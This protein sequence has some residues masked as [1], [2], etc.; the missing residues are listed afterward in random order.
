MP[1]CPVN[2]VSQARLNDSNAFYN[3][4][5][6]TLYLR[7]TRQPRQVLGYVPRINNSFIFET[8]PNQGIAIRLTRVEMTDNNSLYQWPKH[9]VY[10]TASPTKLTTW[11]ARLGHMNFTWTTKYLKER[12][13]PY[14]DDVSEDYYCD[15]CKMAKATKNYNRIPQ[16][17]ASE[18]F[19]EIHTDMV[20][21]IKPTGF[22]NELYFFTFT[23]SY[24]RFTHVYTAT[25]KHE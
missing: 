10:K 19:Q 4:E 20:G 21:Q 8:I 6:W 14:T 18:S 1:Q 5:D 17:H 24:S 23:D 15:P 3:N 2:L 9:A 11:H 13:I 12:G 7:S 25:R 16:E 22:L